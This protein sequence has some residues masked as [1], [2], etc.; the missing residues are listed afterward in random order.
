MIWRNS[1]RLK[2]ERSD[3]TGDLQVSLK[4]RLNCIFLVVIK[5]SLNSIKIFLTLS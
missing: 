1:Y 5:D 4:V 2:G 3:Q